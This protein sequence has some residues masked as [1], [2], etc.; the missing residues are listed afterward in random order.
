MH[1]KTIVVTPFQQNC[2]L[3]IDK[4]NK[5]GV[6]IDP[7]GDVPDIVRFIKSDGVH[8]SKVLLT[9]AHIDH[10]GGV[11]ALL[12]EL[13]QLQGEEPEL[14]G[15]EIEQDMRAQ[16]S[17]QAM[18][19]GL[20]VEEY[21]SVREPDIYVQ[22]GDKLELA[23]MEGKALFTPGHSPGHICIY[24]ESGAFQAEYYRAG[25]ADVIDQREINSPVLIAGDALFAG[26]IGRTDLPG[27]DHQTLINS[28]NSKIMRLPD[29][30]VVMPGHGPDT[31]VGRERASNP[32]L[33]P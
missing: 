24:F 2:R 32:F 10:A 11:M 13:K 31:S 19:F 12:A 18:M 21:K 5:R 28:I 15:H 14:L 8:I 4:A 20:P 26:S 16:L 30:T 7:G 33:I 27:G 17:V 29:D 22:D 23:G 6:V 3:L 9:H 1:I 25:S